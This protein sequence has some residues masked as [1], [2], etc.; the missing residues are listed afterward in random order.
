MNQRREDAL[1]RIHCGSY[2]MTQLY[3]TNVTHFCFLQ[4]SVVVVGTETNQHTHTESVLFNKLSAA[5]FFVQSA[6]RH[7][8]TVKVSLLVVCLSVFTARLTRIPPIGRARQTPSFSA[9]FELRYMPY[10]SS[11]LHYIRCCCRLG[12]HICPCKIWRFCV[13]R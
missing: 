9:V 2:G 1:Q 5:N 6:Q 12:Q 11:R 4:R 13:Q 3:K 7:F 10:G 8:C